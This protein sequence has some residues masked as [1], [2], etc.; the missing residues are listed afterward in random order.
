MSKFTQYS[1][2][3][4]NWKNE[5][6]GFDNE[7]TIGSYGCLL[8]CM[9]MVASAYGREINPHELNNKMK[10]AGGFQGPLVI[11]AQLP[12]VVP[13]VAFKDFER[14]HDHPAPLGQIDAYLAAGKPVIV[15]VDYSPKDGLQ[16]H[17]VVL[18]DKKNSDYLLR[19]PYPYPVESKDILLSQSRYSF[20]GDAKKIITAVVFLDGKPASAP[21][22]EPPKPVEPPV[23]NPT[24][25]VFAAVN[26]LALRKSPFVESDNLIKRLALNEELGVLELAEQGKAKVGVVNEWLCVQNKIGQVG[27]VAAW[28]TSFSKVTPPPEQPAPIQPPSVTPKEGLVLK[29]L[30]EGLALRSQPRVGDDTLIKYLPINSN[31]RLLEPEAQA[32]GKIGAT[33][34]WLK[35]QDIA[36]DEG[37]VAAW[38][39]S[40]AA[41]TA[42]GASDKPKAPPPSGTPA[43]LIVRSNTPDLALRSQTVISDQTLIKRLPL[44]TDLEVLEPPAQAAGKVGVVN[45]WLK[46]KDISGNEG[47]V[48]AW[49]VTKV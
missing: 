36:G 27:Y 2:M 16:N 40:A 30:V 47:Y 14:C 23:K 31:L 48:A 29:A 15:E 17:W 44:G 22:A 32:K 18:Y 1:Q 10:A 21:P 43:K 6:L 46:V 11:P 34:Q 4:P 41:E 20:A 24:F 38:Y 45:Q 3:D 13:E 9:A 28:Y 12:K 19:D 42:L 37:Y 49:Y 26:E 25:Q 35:V 39:V 7:S 5:K 33:D 8:T